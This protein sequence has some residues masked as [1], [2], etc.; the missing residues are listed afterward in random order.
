[1]FIRQY[2]DYKINVFVTWL[3]KLANLMQFFYL[4]KINSAKFDKLLK[5]IKS[6]IV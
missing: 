5:N 4:F 1:M 3:F 2:K 6:I